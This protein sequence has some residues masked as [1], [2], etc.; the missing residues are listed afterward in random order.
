MMLCFVLKFFLR[1]GENT[2]KIARQAVIGAA[3]AL[4]APAQ[5]LA[6]DWPT[7]SVTVVV[8]VPAGVASDII[9]RVVFEQVGKQVGQSF[10]IEN[11]PGAGGTIGANMV[12]KA[13]SDGHTI[14]VYGAIA[15]ANALYARLPYDT[16]A[17][18]APVVPFGETPLVVVTAAGRYNTLAELIAAAKAKPGELNYS[19]VGIGSAAHFGA[20]RLAVSAGITAQH[21]PFKGPEW[22]SDTIAGR[23]DFSVPPVTTVIGP[24]RDGKLKAL[25]VG[26]AKRAASLPDVPTLIE[27]GLRADAIYPFYTGAYLPARTPR[28]IVD[29]LH[30][31]VVNA[32]SLP[33]TQERLAKIG[34]EKLSMTVAEFDQFFKDD[35]GRNLELVKAANIPR[36]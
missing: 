35:V 18:F 29:K 16:I 15:A 27:A 9:A 20:V 31:E 4:I 21:I 22:L 24:I 10:V 6:Q 7:H 34:V 5:A 30:D 17:D 2:M 3:I 26:A 25:A 14:L 23:V 32:L 28:A 11:R 19:T 1:F 8:P 12:A 36:Q 13:T 33:S